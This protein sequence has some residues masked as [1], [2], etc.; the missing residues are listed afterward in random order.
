MDNIECLFR[1]LQALAYWLG[2]EHELFPFK[3]LTELAI[4]SELSRLISISASRN[5]DV[6]VEYKYKDIC[7]GFQNNYMADI[8]LKSKNINNNNIVIE[9][10]RY[11]PKQIVKDIEKIRK[12]D[13]DRVSKYLLICSE[14]KFPSDFVDNDFN[15]KRHIDSKKYP[16]CNV[17]RV[18]KA[19]KSKK[20]KNSN[21]VILIKVN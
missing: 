6:F 8:Y 1:S 18:L 19:L 9:I 11:L 15:A 4:A 3:H 7:E 17:K 10:K 16:K 14:M 2:Y 5:Y 13:C 21:F 20:V 12:L